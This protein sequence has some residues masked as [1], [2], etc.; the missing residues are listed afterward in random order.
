MLWIML[1]EDRLDKFFTKPEIA[2]KCIGLIKNTIDKDSY[3]L[4]VEPSAGAGAFLGFFANERA[5]DIK[6]NR[7]D[8]EEKDFFNVTLKD[9]GTYDNKSI[10]I[11]GNPPFG[12]VSSLAIKF[13]NHAATLADTICFIVPRTFKKISTHKKLNLYFHL[14]EEMELPENSFI[15]NGEDYN[16]PCVF[17]I[18]TK[19]NY[20]RNIE[21]LENIFLEFISKEEA[22]TDT[23]CI[24]RAGSRAGR[25]LEGTDHS[26][27][28]TYFA[29][30]IHPMVRE[31]LKDI[32]LDVACYTV[33]QKSISKEEL[34]RELY[35][36]HNR[37]IYQ[38]TS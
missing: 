35:L 9:L 36:V 29:N 33:G 25:V 18:W 28:S 12:K 1:R 14:V 22:S 8:I 5:F 21:K 6:P 30:P 31:Y 13:F 34:I 4:V 11:V 37:N 32:N 17:Q 19:K 2:E 38:M 20:K 7:S 16:V 27:S 3:E 23:L 26:A 10:M 24:R 15:F